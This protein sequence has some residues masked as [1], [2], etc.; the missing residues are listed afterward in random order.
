M[1]GNLKHAVEEK[2]TELD[3]EETGL[4]ESDILS[5]GLTSSRLEISDTLSWELLMLL[6]A[7]F[8]IFSLLL[9]PLLPY[10]DMQGSIET[11]WLEY[12]FSSLVTFGIFFL[13]TIPVA[14]GYTWF[15]RKWPWNMVTWFMVVGSVGATV[16]IVS[17]LTNPRG[18]FV[19][20]TGIGGLLFVFSILRLLDV[21]LFTGFTPWLV[22]IACLAICFLPICLVGLL[23]FPT[24]Y[25]APLCGLGISLFFLAELRLMEIGATVNAKLLKDP[26]TVCVW[27]NCAMWRF[28]VQ[29]ALLGIKLLLHATIWLLAF[30]W[31]SVKWT[32]ASLFSLVPRRWWT[33]G[34][35][36][37]RLSHVTSS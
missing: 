33:P 7:E 1:Y 9:S 30:M 10:S 4:A 15:V 17:V 22:S 36:V 5:T 11:F 21:L 19:M 12:P 27:V 29:V 18:T 28:L 14:A 24:V 16:H 13:L 8:L 37:D 32:I 20:T 25:V 3:D 35:T 31:K 34:E 6:S 26:F 2:A 23:S